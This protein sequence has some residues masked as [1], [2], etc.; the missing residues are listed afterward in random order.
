MGNTFLIYLVLRLLGTPFFTIIII[1]VV[2]YL[3][4]RFFL[5]VL[6]NIFAP[7]KRRSTSKRLESELRINPANASNAMELGILYLDRKRYSRALE[8]LNK[9]YERIKDSDRLFLYR[10]MALIETGSRQEGVDNLRKAVAINEG[11]G[12]G[13]PYVYLLS[14]AMKDPGISQE[15]RKTLQDKFWRYANTENLYRMGMMY[16]RHGDRENAKEMFDNAI[17]EYSYCP[18]NLKKLHRR[19]ALLSMLNRV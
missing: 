12:Y 9:A 4:D 10:G 7:I 18:R 8:Y 5:G 2:I 16:K 19:W 14:N 3:F 6:P 17:K 11:T 1:L 13:L 15:E